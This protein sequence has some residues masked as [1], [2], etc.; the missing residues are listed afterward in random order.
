[1]S[2]VKSIHSGI[3]WG[4]IDTFVRQGVQFVIG[5]IL[6]RILSPSEFG[7]LGILTI[8]LSLSDL[9]IES[10]FAQALIRKKN[11]TQK[12]YSTVFYFNFALSLI[13][14]FIIILSAGF[15]EDYFRVKGLAIM[16]YVFMLKIV[17][18]SFYFI[19]TIK[20]T[21][22]LDFKMFTKISF[23]SSILSGVI[24]I[25]LAYSGFGVWS[26]IWQSLSATVLIALSVN[27]FRFWMPSISFEW[28]IIKSL[29]KIS[30]Y[31]MGASLLSRISNELNTFVIGRYF[32]PVALGHYSRANS[33]KDLPS[34]TFN[35]IISK[36]SLPILSDK[37]NN[38][39]ELQIFYKKLFYNSFFLSS[40]IMLLLISVADNLILFL[41]G[42]KWSD[43]IVLFQFLSVVGILYP[44]NAINNNLIIAVGKTSKT[45]W[46]GIFKFISTI[47]VLIIGSMTSIKVLV[48][49]I[50]LVSFIH[51]LAYCYFSGKLVNY[52]LTEQFFDVLKQTWYLVVFCLIICFID[53]TLLNHL[54][55]LIV[56]MSI[57]LLATI[58]F[59]IFFKT[60]I[61]KMSKNAI[62]TY[63]MK[64]KT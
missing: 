51:T 39:E 9:L 4:S 27:I 31:L 28:N 29:Y 20:L 13:F 33:L 47:P 2:K 6:A 23:I 21:Q 38:F 14:Y 49:G 19:Q 25:F 41:L 57:F 8:F 54:G 34:Q 3:F 52:S 44:L 11:N 16:L 43:T 50:V 58:F 12:E 64:N 40:F 37:Q 18:S 55:N 24:G 48:I 30:S 7:V 1:M 5:I 22:S 63:L 45:F 46:L 17:I 26:L 15:I 42:E 35:T 53:F 10:G 32:S 60:E 56:K 59:N 36:V 62:S 61:Y